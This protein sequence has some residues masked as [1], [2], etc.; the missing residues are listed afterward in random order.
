[1]KTV[2][3][4]PLND[5]QLSLLRIFSHPISEAQTLKIK[6]ILVQFL[7]DELDSEVERVVQKKNIT[8]DDYDRL[9]NEHQ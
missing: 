4:L 7:S 3:P 6:R 2:D 5:V 1:M 8:N 9:R